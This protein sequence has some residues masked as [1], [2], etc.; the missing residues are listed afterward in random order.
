MLQVDVIDWMPCYLM[1]NL[2]D[3]FLSVSSF[4]LT[5]N[6]YS[7]LIDKMR[8]N[9]EP[10]DRFSPRRVEY[11]ITEVAASLFKPPRW[12]TF[13]FFSLF[14]LLFHFFS[15]TS[16]VLIVWMP[17]LLFSVVWYRNV[18]NNRSS[19]LCS[20]LLGTPWTLN[21]LQVVRHET[22]SSLFAES[23][24]LGAKEARERS[25]LNL[26]LPSHSLGGSYLF[27]I[28]VIY[29]KMIWQNFGVLISFHASLWCRGFLHT[30]FFQHAYLIAVLLIL[31]TALYLFLRDFMS[32]RLINLALMVDAQ[33]LQDGALWPT[34]Y[35]LPFCLFSLCWCPDSLW[36][37]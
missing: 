18:F 11:D 22:R 23:G 13:L 29:L 12:P 32:S 34:W 17:L 4:S 31:S 9:E 5:W 26:I 33:T 6:S 21:S 2:A 25:A 15:V 1:P 20:L 30:V 19:D 16:L 8:R 10:H 35:E 24:V 3:S 14:V 7:L 36:K 37:P 28:T 27:S